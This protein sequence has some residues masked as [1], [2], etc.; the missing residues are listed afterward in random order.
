VKKNLF[1][2]DLPT[3]AVITGH[4][5][6][7]VVKVMGYLGVDN[8]VKVKRQDGVELKVP[9]AFLRSTTKTMNKMFK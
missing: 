9:A 8:M 1:H 5:R 2:A 3:Y 4:P 7:G 6:E